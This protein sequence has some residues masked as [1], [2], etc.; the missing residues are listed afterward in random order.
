MRGPRRPTLAGT[1]LAALACSVT[2]P[3]AAEPAAGDAVVASSKGQDIQIEQRSCERLDLARLRNLLA[4]EMANVL[5]RLG[6]LA[7]R[8]TCGDQQIT[9]HLE[10]S[11]F[12]AAER[13]LPT[14]ALGAVEP[15]RLLALAGAQLAFAAWFDPLLDGSDRPET[16]PREAAVRQISSRPVTAAAPAQSLGASSALE[17]GVEAGARARALGVVVVGPSI[18]LLATAWRGAWGAELSLAVDRTA[19]ARSLGSAELVDFEV[20]VSPVWRSSQTKAFAVELSGGPAVAV[21]DLRGFAPDTHVTA[22][23]VVGAT[24]DARAAVALRYRRAGFWALAR[25][26]GGY[27]VSGPVGTITGESAIEAQGP[28][29]GATLALGGGW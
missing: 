10:S 7:V 18:G 5:G 12:G 16:S 21:L 8:V 11:Q 3:S 27:L 23:S 26:E 6:R 15:E 4:L 29:V 22:S 24:M 14:R 1:V 9:L 28:W 2:S 17:I 19:A 20:G 25:L 13:A